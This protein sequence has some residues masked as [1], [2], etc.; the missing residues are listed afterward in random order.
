MSKKALKGRDTGKI[1]LKSPD[2]D[3]KL[4]EEEI[5][6]CKEAFDLFDLDNS[7]TIDPREVQ[8]ALNSLGNDKSPTFF[9]LLSGI[10]ELGAE[11]DF[12]SFLIHVNERLGNKES[13]KGVEKILELFD[14]EGTGNLTLKA[15][16]RVSRELGETMTEDEMINCL[17]RISSLSKPELTL[18]DFYRV[19][20]RK[21]YGAPSESVFSLPKNVE[22]LGTM[23]KKE[24]PKVTIRKEESKT[25]VKR[26]EIKAEKIREEKKGN[27]LEG[28]KEN[29][30]S[31]ERD[32]NKDTSIKGEHK[33]YIMDENSGFAEDKEQSTI[34]LDKDKSNIS[35]DAHDT[36]ITIEKNQTISKNNEKDEFMEEGELIENFSRIKSK[37]IMKKK[38]QKLR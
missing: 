32:Y 33:G 6:D 30:L 37:G 31:F 13:K 19:M 5:K 12:N 36:N 34:L 8:A 23:Q 7:G 2:Y 18:D 16:K 26:E 25:L 21:V 17:E 4:T 27:L 10:E 9:R 14:A 1:Q 20:V 3:I 22:G 35:I 29:S 28:I 38:K 11:I 15:Y 24:E